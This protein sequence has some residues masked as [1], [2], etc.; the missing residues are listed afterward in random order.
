MNKK[1]KKHYHDVLNNQLNSLLERSGFELSELVSQNG[2][3][4]EELDRASADIDQSLRL[5]FRSRESRLIKKIQAALVKI[6]DNTYGICESC[7]EN[8]SARRLE[9]RPVTTKC[10]ICKTEEEKMELLVS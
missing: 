3:E 6:Q 10:I 4:I 5:R 1:Q 8:I 2:K 7:G 9:A